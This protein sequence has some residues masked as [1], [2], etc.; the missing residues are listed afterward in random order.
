MMQS[1]NVSAHLPTFL[2]LFFGWFFYLFCR[3]A[4]SSTTPQ[5]S[6]N[7][8]FTKDQLGTITSS[9]SLAYGVSKF[10]GAIASDRTDL[11]LLFSSGLFFTGLT[12]FMFP[13][14]TTVSYCSV[15]IFLQGF[16]QGAGWPAV[17]KILKLRFP[18]EHVGLYWSLVGC[19][20]SIGAA[21]SPVLV[22]KFAEAL[23]WYSIYYLV[24]GA[25]VVSSVIIYTVIP[26]GASSKEFHS[27]QRK[28]N[29]ARF[30]YVD[31]L[32]SGDLWLASWIYF[33]LYILKN[34]LCDWGQ[35][36]FIQELGYGQSSGK[37]LCL[38]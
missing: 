27:T 36:Y 24:G 26:S 8:G 35:L 3:K 16:A 33:F 28:T 4:F 12:T 20:G 7:V 37:K 31:L 38:I 15:M 18:P 22:A 25:S 6:Y 30:T 2:A 32:F 29:G 11:G 10:L 14:Q 5:L 1:K 19:A 23:E 13:L 34:A 9:F 21:V 17:A